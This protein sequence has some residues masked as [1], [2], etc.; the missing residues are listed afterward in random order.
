MMDIDCPK[1]CCNARY[2]PLVLAWATTVHKFQGFEAGFDE[3][4][5]VNYIIA[6]INT[7][8]WEK[9][10]PGTAYV[11]ASRAK[12]IGK[13]TA[14]IEHPTK[15]NLF[16]T[17]TMGTR[18]FTRCRYKDNGEVCLAVQKRD[19]WIQHLLDKVELTKARRNQ[20]VMDASTNFVLSNIN[21]SHIHTKKDLQS[22]IIDII[23][24]PKA[25]WRDLRQNYLIA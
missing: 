6:D 10:H 24:E 25:P 17:G 12:T 9:S 8:D 11:V 16:F 21:H 2:C 3:D 5:N 18:R 4:D 19:L 23:R 13:V 1:K 22:S 14:D 7:L 15:S 20:A